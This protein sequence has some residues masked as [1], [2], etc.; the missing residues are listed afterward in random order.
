M[1]TSKIAD[2]K[3]KI[4]NLTMEPLKITITLNTPVVTGKHPICLDGVLNRALALDLWGSAAL[5]MDTSNLP[6]LP[7]PLKK[8]GFKKEY[9]HASIMFYKYGVYDNSTW[10]KTADYKDQHL[11][12]PDDKT[13]VDIGRGYFKS[14][15]ITMTHLNDDKVYFYANG[16]KDEI[17][18]LLKLITHLGKKSSQGYGRI[19]K[20]EIT[21][22]DK[23]KSVFCDNKLMRP[24][25]LSELKDSKVDMYKIVTSYKP[26]YFDIR[27]T[28]LCGVPTPDLWAIR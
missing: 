6:D 11:E 24:V 7:L 20:I 10:Y 16:D 18:R 3:K 9:Y 27:N 21:M 26:C 22:E 12:D 17:K 15:N 28:T 1:N 5:D 14:C 13:K 2:Y 23:D 19:G 4:K 25:P 8:S